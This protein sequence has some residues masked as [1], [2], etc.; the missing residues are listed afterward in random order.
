M[1]LHGQIVGLPQQRPPGAVLDPNCC[2]LSAGEIP[3]RE[4]LR[5]SHCYFGCRECVIQ[6]F[7]TLPV[8][9]LAGNVPAY[10]LPTLGRVDFHRRIV[11]AG[12]G[13]R[14]W[15]KSWSTLEYNP[16]LMHRF[17]TRAAPRSF[18]PG[19]KRFLAVAPRPKFAGLSQLTANA[20]GGYADSGIPSNAVSHPLTPCDHAP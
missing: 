16:A 11:P 13:L 2:V 18:C 7:N 14:N 4:E 5:W 20:T 6:S 15:E 19:P 12:T 17:C 3:C 1:G 10:N 8:C 9:D